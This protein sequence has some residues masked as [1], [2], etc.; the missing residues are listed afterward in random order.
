MRL[1]TPHPQEI[2]TCILPLN[3]SIV[4]LQSNG[5]S[6][7]TTYPD[8]SPIRKTALASLYISKR[9]VKLQQAFRIVY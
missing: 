6:L 4:A 8:L 1:H 9:Q 7:K 2:I 5:R 3:D